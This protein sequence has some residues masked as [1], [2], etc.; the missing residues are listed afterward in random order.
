MT[1]AEEVRRLRKLL[2]TYR[3]LYQGLS[4]YV[5]GWLDAVVVDAGTFADADRVNEIR[6]KVA[7]ELERQADELGID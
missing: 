1:T 2:A 5:G 3:H 7:A 6:R 4:Q